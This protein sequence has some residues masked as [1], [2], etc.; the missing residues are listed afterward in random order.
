MFYETCISAFSVIPEGIEDTIGTSRVLISLGDIGYDFSIN[1]IE[2]LL[3]E[4]A[5]KSVKGTL[6]NGLLYKSFLHSG[7]EPIFW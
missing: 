4:A 3:E 6:S 1:F 5:K 2:A 7:C